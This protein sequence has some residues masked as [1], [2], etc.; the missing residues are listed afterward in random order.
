MLYAID[1]PKD[2]YRSLNKNAKINPFFSKDIV[3]ECVRL[4]SDY[5]TLLMMRS[6]SVCLT[7]MR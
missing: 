3:G 6:R 5:Y 7:L 4:I 1:I 2:V